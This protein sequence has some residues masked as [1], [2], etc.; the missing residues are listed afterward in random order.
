MLISISI[1]KNN[2]LY[3]FPVVQNPI[4]LKYKK[5]LKNKWSW[6]EKRHGEAIWQSKSIQPLILHNQSNSTVLFI[7]QGICEEKEY[8]QLKRWIKKYHT[9]VLVL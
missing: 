6:K 5:A 3:I 2:A 8:F 4:S 1:K 7:I 9:K